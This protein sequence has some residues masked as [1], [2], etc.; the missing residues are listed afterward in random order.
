MLNDSPMDIVVIGIAVLTESIV[1]SCVC[2]NLIFK[3]LRQYLTH[4]NLDT[5]N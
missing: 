3:C 4:I 2:S 1:T 5:A